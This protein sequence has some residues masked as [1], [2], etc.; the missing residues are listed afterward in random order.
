MKKEGGVSIV[1]CK[2]N[3]LNLSFIFDTGASD[4]TISLTEASFMLK[5]GYL[6][7]EDIIGSEKYLDATGNISEGI[8][9]NLREIE[10]EGL[11]LQNV[12]AS[13]VKTLNAPLLLGQSALS[14]LGTI[15]L[16]LD[17]NQLTIISSPS[18]MIK[19]DFENFLTK[20][21]M[22]IFKD[23]FKIL[24][25]SF[26]DSIPDVAKLANYFTLNMSAELK[27]DSLWYIP[28][29]TYL[30]LNST[31]YFY[32]SVRNKK[33]I[34][35][36]KSINST[37]YN[38]LFLEMFK[39]LK[40]YSR[41]KNIK[42]ELFD[43]SS[44]VI[45]N[46]SDNELIYLFDCAGKQYAFLT[47]IDKDI[48]EKEGIK[49]YLPL[50]IDSKSF[51]DYRN[52]IFG[53]YLSE[54]DDIKTAEDQN[55]QLSYFYESLAN[56]NENDYGKLPNSDKELFSTLDYE[57]AFWCERAANLKNSSDENLLRKVGLFTKGIS[58][59]EEYSYPN[60]KKTYYY[61]RLYAGRADCKYILED[62]SGAYEDY[63]KIIS[64]YENN[65]ASREA[66]K[67]DITDYYYDYSNI[68]YFLKKY[69][70]C[71]YSIQK[72]IATYSKDLDKYLINVTLYQLYTLKGYLDYF[73]FKNKE[74]ACKDWSRAGELGD[75]DAY[76]YIKQY[77]NK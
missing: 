54:I 4:V 7:K 20:A 31:S 76:D 8:V 37:E 63:K 40:S 36:L 49:V 17:R 67:T 13:I 47:N 16:D 60:M 41:E 12:K 18:L 1:P 34:T 68:C 27:S 10:I 45:E 56:Y 28:S 53:K 72:G 52:L 71:K 69:E 38:N 14:K 44:V 32:T 29:D 24:A 48:S 5:N 26:S 39:S 6:K 58:L 2:V 30:D 19:D 21:N 62:Y 23:A 43:T 51:F 9:I 3:G 73:I 15:K 59:F 70:E 75:K 46:N 66:L 33:N 22:E 74:Q 50:N 77:C 25:K 65:P 42:W 61:K 35:E 11:K 57:P 55:L 64:V